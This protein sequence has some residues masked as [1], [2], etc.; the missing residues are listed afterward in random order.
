MHGHWG[1]LNFIRSRWTV[2]FR[3][4]YQSEIDADLHPVMFIKPAI[5]LMRGTWP[6]C[7][8]SVVLEVKNNMQRFPICAERRFD[9]WGRDW[10]MGH[11]Y[12]SLISSADMCGYAC[13]IYAI[14]IIYILYAKD[15]CMRTN[16]DRNNQPNQNLLQ[17][18]IC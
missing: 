12:D 10:Q 16:I 8:F 1:M 17:L 13:H 14:I 5:I 6:N 18:L 4:I 9:A 11:L 15:C 3:I 2:R 7:G